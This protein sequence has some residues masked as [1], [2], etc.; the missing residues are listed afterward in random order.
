LKGR[1]FILLFLLFLRLLPGWI[2][3]GGY[4][5]AQYLKITGKMVKIEQKRSECTG[6]VGRFW[7]RFEDK[8][9]FSQY[10]KVSLFGRVRLTVIDRILGR[11]W[12]DASHKS[13]KILR[14]QTDDGNGL[15]KKID[16]ERWRENLVDI[17]RQLLPEPEGSLVAGVVLGYKDLPYDF[18]QK[19]INSG[20]IH[21][22]VASGYNVMIVGEMVLASL[23]YIMV[24]SRASILAVLVMFV[25]ALLTGFDPPVVRAVIMGGILIAGQGLGRSGMSW[26]SLLVAIWLM[27]II[28]PL[29]ML[30]IG[31]QLSV[32]ASMGLLFIGP[33]AREFL[34]NKWNGVWLGIL[35]KTEFLP[36]FSAQIMTAPLIWWYF[37]RISWVGLVSNI[38]VLPLVP[39]LMLL[40]AVMLVLGMIWLP[41]GWI[42]GWAT[43][44][45]AHLVVVMVEWFG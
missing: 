26:W 11:I 29:V 36:T 4:K 43:Y 30:S 44:S 40:G 5:E 21:I 13:I 16:F 24:R 15:R 10:D 39:V 17:Y 20:T 27:V 41:L 9:E 22:I 18:Y 37:G 2:E 34:E 1:L 6:V 45:L 42:V 23:F 32:A 8:C 12:L 19:L 35:L 33:K 14:V 25:Y 38:F 7:I 31:F 3:A 28:E